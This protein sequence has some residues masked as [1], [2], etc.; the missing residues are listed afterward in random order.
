M[1]SLPRPAALKGR[2]VRICPLMAPGRGNVQSVLEA[3][4][5]NRRRPAHATRGRADGVGASLTRLWSL[6]IRRRPGCAKNYVRL[7]LSLVCSLKDTPLRPVSWDAMFTRRGRRASRLR[8]R[9]TGPRPSA[10]SRARRRPT[11]S[12]SPREVQPD[13]KRKQQH[14]QL[15]PHLT[16]PSVAGLAD[17]LRCRWR[18]KLIPLGRGHRSD[19][20]LGQQC[21]RDGSDLLH[22]LLRGVRNGARLYAVDPIWTSSA[23]RSGRAPCRERIALANAVGREI[24]AAGL[25]DKAFIERATSDYDG[26]QGQGRGL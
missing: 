16:R 10:S 6:S 7:T 22:H 15:Q 9:S 12:T 4:R 8:R 20:P 19:R 13:R 3:T 18:H 17:R 1:G 25:E 11:R 14:R 5:L 2:R 24:I 21:P 23:E 26:G